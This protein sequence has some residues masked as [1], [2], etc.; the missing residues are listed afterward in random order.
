MTDKL[1]TRPLPI[2]DHLTQSFWN[3]A[4]DHHLVLQQCTDCEKFIHVPKI[5]CPFCL[6]TALTYTEV[7]GR[8]TIYSFTLAEHMYHP[9]LP[10]PYILATVELEEQDGL[11]MVSNITDCEYEDLA[12]GLALQVWFSEVAPGVVLPQFRL[13]R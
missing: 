12:I 7:S 5:M 4:R 11:R 2:P 10:T 1:L 13:A 6:S 9:A 8:G 3:G